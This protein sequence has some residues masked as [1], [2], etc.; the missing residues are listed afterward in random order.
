MP[1]SHAI[2][3]RMMRHYAI[4]EFLGMEK[5]FSA[6]FRFRVFPFVLPDRPYKKS[7]DYWM[8]DCCIKAQF[9]KVLKCFEKTVALMGQQM[10]RKQIAKLSENIHEIASAAV[11]LHP[12]PP[13]GLIRKI[14]KSRPELN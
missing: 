13:K 5:N 8:V 6:Y 4:A 3:A 7:T 2:H 9:D 14:Q 12:K 10:F 11:E 1:L